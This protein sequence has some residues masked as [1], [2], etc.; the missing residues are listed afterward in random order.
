MV[1]RGL[2]SILMRSYFNVDPTST[3]RSEKLDRVML[4]VIAK[5]HTPHTYMQSQT[6]APIFDVEFNQFQRINPTEA[7][8]LFFSASNQ[9]R[10][11][12]ADAKTGNYFTFGLLGA[13][14]AYAIE[15]VI[16]HSI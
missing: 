5:S 13:V 12:G 11:L 2:V 8:S 4:R 6:V 3:V 1:L 9:N 15:I 16:F 7:W 10:L 14:V